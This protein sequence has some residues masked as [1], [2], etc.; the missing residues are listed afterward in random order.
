MVLLDGVGMD[1][2]LAA[3][4]AGYPRVSDGMYNMLNTMVLEER[5]VEVEW[6]L[7][8]SM[9]ESEILPYYR[10]KRIKNATIV[11]SAF[12]LFNPGLLST[13]YI[14]NLLRVSY[15]RLQ[16]RRGSATHPATSFTWSLWMGKYCSKLRSE[17]NV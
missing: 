1:H 9:G 14:L 11:V 7:G 10:V 13:V 16:Q 12:S 8:K 15:Q 17:I 6:P 3:N 2:A 4:A 5:G